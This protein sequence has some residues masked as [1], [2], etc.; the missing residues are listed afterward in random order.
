MKKTLI[1][2]AM[3]LAVNGAK[4]AF[5]EEPSMP[6]PGEEGL[7]CLADGTCNKGLFCNDAGLCAKDLGIYKPKTP[8]NIMAIPK[9]PLK[10][11]QAMK[12]P[13]DTMVIP[14][15]DKFLKDAVVKALNIFP[16]AANQGPLVTYG[17]CKKLTTLDAPN[18]N[19]RLLNGIEYCKNLTWLNLKGNDIVNISPLAG[20]K[21][22]AQ[23]SL[24]ENNIVDISPLTALLNLSW[25]G[26]SGNEIEAITPLKVNAQNDGLGE[27]DKV[28][29]ND[30]P[31]DVGE[32]P[33]LSSSVVQLQA[34]WNKET[35]DFLASRK[36]LVWYDT[37][38]V[39]ADKIASPYN[40]ADLKN[41]DLINFKDDNLRELVAKSIKKPKGSQITI[42]EC[43][44]K[45]TELTSDSCA[46]PSSPKIKSLEGL[47]YCQSL[48]KISLTCN[49]IA[50][51]GPLKTITSLTK[52]DLRNNWLSDITP[53][54]ALTNLSWLDISESNSE[55]DSLKPLKALKSNGG[56]PSGSYVWVPFYD[57]NS[58]ND[59]ILKKLEKQGVIVEM[60][61]Y[62][63]VP[64][65]PAE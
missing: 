11:P 29:L 22:L 60:V 54:S 58:E 38:P 45:L 32:K 3:F 17:I 5:A 33:Y 19:I 6:N 21:N 64:D 27:G 57:E 43:Q 10:I 36:V 2:L 39:G 15:A 18:S 50:D 20:L 16:K 51:I 42:T 12:E 44:N 40:M 48:T 35:L 53:L 25:L 24:A 26:L 34:Y 61:P 52:L 62:V 7:V 14:F 55:I 46:N 63:G 23:L 30:N 65:L 37:L 1:L 47:E 59:I 49:D 31:F 28:Y 4:A 8:K 41:I 9:G 56:L 13:A